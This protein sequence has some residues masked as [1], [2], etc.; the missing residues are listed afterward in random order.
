MFFPFFLFS[1]LREVKAKMTVFH[2]T[3]ESP[4]HIMLSIKLHYRN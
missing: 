4:V 2:F 3:T 1:F